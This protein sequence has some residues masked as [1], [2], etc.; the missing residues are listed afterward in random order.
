MWMLAWYDSVNLISSKT[1]QIINK[2][3]VWFK[4]NQ[5]DIKKKTYWIDHS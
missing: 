3:E 4:K 1:T 5:D 2:K